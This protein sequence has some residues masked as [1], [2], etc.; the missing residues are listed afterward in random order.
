[1]I[2]KLIRKLFIASLND[3]E[4]KHLIICGQKL[5]YPDLD[6][7]TIYSY[8]N[9]LVLYEQTEDT[10]NSMIEYLYLDKYKNR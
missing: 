9:D 3:S 8:I 4:K 5:Q 10:I 6:G 2:K 7:R 1:M